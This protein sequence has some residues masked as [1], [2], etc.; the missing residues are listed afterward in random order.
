MF[1]IL[2]SYIFPAFARIILDGIVL[3]HC[4]KPNV[5]EVPGIFGR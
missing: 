4:Y 5:I 1:D 3:F 2:L